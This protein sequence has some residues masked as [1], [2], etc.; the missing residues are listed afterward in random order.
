MPH[1]ISQGFV[2]QGTRQI[3]VL[4]ELDIRKSNG[5]AYQ[6]FDR[7]VAGP[8]MCEHKIWFAQV[9]NEKFRATHF[10]KGH[11]FVNFIE[12]NNYIV[13]YCIGEN[14][15][16]LWRRENRMDDDP[17]SVILRH[18]SIHGG[19]E[20]Q[21]YL[22]AVKLDSEFVPIA[23]KDSVAKL[24][25]NEIRSDNLR[26]KIQIVSRRWKVVRTKE[27]FGC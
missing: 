7:S 13:E 26:K 19:I 4:N 24:Y 23:F 14:A 21:T 2:F 18:W 1:S 25:L 10:E 12:N 27:T 9:G 8:T 17:L 3:D 22:G 20:K 11:Y 6:R 16:D 15:A 5:E